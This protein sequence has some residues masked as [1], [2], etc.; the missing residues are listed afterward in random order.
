MNALNSN[1]SPSKT[2]TSLGGKVN[3]SVCFTRVSVCFRR[4]LFK[5]VSCEGVWFTWGAGWD[6]ELGQGWHAGCVS[7]HLHWVAL[8]WTVLETGSRCCCASLKAVC[9]SARADKS[10]PASKVTGPASW[11]F[12]GDFPSFCSRNAECDSLRRTLWIF[13]TL[14]VGS[15]GAIWGFFQ[16][17]LVLY[18]NIHSLHLLGLLVFQLLSRRWF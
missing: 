14:F 8:P 9:I 5:A 13:I 7:L 15:S 4:I 10:E 18:Q 12:R 3:K 2:L 6:L 1:G 11:S 17:H 16:M